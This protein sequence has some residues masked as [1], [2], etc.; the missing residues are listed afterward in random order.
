MALTPV[1][2][3]R[4]ALAAEHPVELRFIDMLLVI[5][6]TLMFVTI[7]LSVVSAFTGSGRPDTAPR[8][9]TR[10]APSALVG[11]QY[12]LTLAVTG[13]DG[14]FT[15]ETAAGA[16]PEGL[17]L[18]ADGVIEGVP[19]K[20]ETSVVSVRVRDGAGRSSEPRELGLTVR[21]SSVSGVEQAPLRVTS[22][23][24]L[25]DDAVAGSDYLHRFGADS[26]L[27]PYTWSVDA[28][29]EGL[30]LAPDG[31]LAGR[32]A[33]AG[34]TTFTV[35]LTDATGTTAHQEVR[36]IVQEA[37]ESLFWRV[38][39][40][41]KTIVTWLGYLLLI[42]TFGILTWEYLMGRPETVVPGRRG[43]LR[44]GW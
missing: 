38:L 22:A 12:Q 3:R 4:R 39:N 27:P 29:P 44:R 11:L 28:L 8:I 20:E 1:F 5:I 36:L 17:R 9:A 30:S 33:H 26:G 42:L 13:G 14:D 21:P 41:F 24:S 35:A 34:A 2:V 16:L 7:V 23:V 18:R 10:S 32:P 43:K 25:L 19:A 37:P 15:W 31:A 40:W 6:A